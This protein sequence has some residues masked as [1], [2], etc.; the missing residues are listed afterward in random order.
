MKIY[1]NDIPVRIRDARRKDI[2][3]YDLKLIDTENI[4]PLAKLK[5]HVLIQN[6]SDSAIDK[7]LKIMTNKK[8]HKLKSVEIVVKNKLKAQE[9]LISHFNLVEAAGGIVEKDDKILLIHRNNLWDIPKGK[10][11]K[12]ETKKDG[13]ER[14]VEEE[15]G[16]KVKIIEKI[17]ATW[18]TYL[19][20]HKYVIKKTH[21][22]RMECLDDSNIKPQKEENIDKALFMTNSEVDIAMYHSYRT[23]E[24]VVKKYREIISK[25]VEV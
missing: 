20:N 15:T 3:E 2:K 18:H 11:E 16:A 5:G 12:K 13:A 8:H 19:M 17:C 4:I 7:L 14:E 24:Q 22:Y 21:W 1:I 9:Y 10:L 6:K 25:N 23:I